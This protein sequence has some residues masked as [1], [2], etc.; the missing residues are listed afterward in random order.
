MSIHALHE[1]FHPRVEN[2]V[3]LGLCHEC[4]DTRPDG[5]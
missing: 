4:F 2:D 1:R 5:T 3:I